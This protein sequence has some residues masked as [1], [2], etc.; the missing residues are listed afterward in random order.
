MFPLKNSVIFPV[1]AFPVN[2]KREAD[3]NAIEAAKSSSQMTLPSS[4]RKDPD[5]DNPG[6]EDL[7]EI[8]T[9]ATILKSP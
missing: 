5:V 1:L 4:L 7:H 2:V 3:A 6:A 8:G 9:L